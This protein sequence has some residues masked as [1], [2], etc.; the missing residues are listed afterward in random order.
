MDSFTVDSNGIRGFFYKP[1]M[2]EKYDWMNEKQDI[3]LDGLDHG[4]EKEWR[5]KYSH[6]N[7][8]KNF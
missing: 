3:F 7:F 2:T 5:K 6:M 8:K 1:N 4:L